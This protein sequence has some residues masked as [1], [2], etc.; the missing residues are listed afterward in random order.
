VSE[1]PLLVWDLVRTA[2]LVERA[3]VAV[4]DDLDLSPTEFG[5]LDALDEDGRGP[6]QAELARRVLVRPQ[7]LHT[8]IGSL[9]DRGLVV[10]DGPAGRGHRTGIVLTDAGRRALARA[11]PT[12]RA[13]NHHTVLGIDGDRAAELDRILADIRAALDRQADAPEAAVTVTSADP[14]GRSSTGNDPTSNE[15]TSNDPTSNE[16]LNATCRGETADNSGS[17]ASP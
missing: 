9:L 13:G 5:V 4:F 3:L 10:R 1:E 8:L 7:S 11:R 2:R 17:D 15:P 12:V 14:T 6:T 16:P